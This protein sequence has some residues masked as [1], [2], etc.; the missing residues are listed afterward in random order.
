MQDKNFELHAF[1][2]GFVQGVFFRATVKHHADSLNIRGQ[3]RN[4][5]DGRVELIA[6]DAKSRLESLLEKIK[7]YPGAGKI[8]DISISYLAPSRDFCTFLIVR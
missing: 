1:Y 5:P 7:K 3:V 6:V 2:S 4:L 8:D